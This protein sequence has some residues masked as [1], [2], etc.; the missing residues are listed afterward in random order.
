MNLKKTTTGIILGTTAIVGATFGID[1]KINPYENFPDRVEMITTS[2]LP[3]SG[4]QKVEIM[5]DKPQ[6]RFK[7]WNGEVN[8]GL[9][10]ND[11]KA[12]GNRPLLSNKM[13]FKDVKQEVAVYPLNATSTEIEVILLEKPVSNIIKFTL[14][15]YQNL[16]FFYQPALTQKEIDE[17]ANRP[18]NVVGSYA[19]YAKEKANHIVGQTNYGTG[20]VGHIYR[21]KIIDSA[22]T[23]VWGDLHIENGILSVTIPQDFLD[24]AVYPVRVDP[25]FGY[26]SIG[27]TGIGGAAEYAD[28]AEGTPASSG[29]VDKLT[30][31]GR[32][33]LGTGDVKGAIWVVSTL[34]LVTNSV[35]NALLN[36]SS[37]AQWRDLT[38]TTPPSVVGGTQYYVGFIWNQ[39]IADPGRYFDTVSGNGWDL[40]TY[41]T[42]TALSAPLGNTTQRHSIYATYQQASTPT[43]DIQSDLIIF[44]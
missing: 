44:E 16:D 17:G 25:T 41:A 37:I 19:V 24:K 20:K 36:I 35:T 34:G 14:D 39:N 32:D 27:A 33:S 2:D 26:T 18:E 43:T 22:G 8:L 9:T 13:E 12:T 40:N 3:N 1:S 15:N 21:P 4:E 7:K 10:Y 23:E 31:Y 29:I 6:V 11:V 28:L 42:P 5:K 30:F 38:Y